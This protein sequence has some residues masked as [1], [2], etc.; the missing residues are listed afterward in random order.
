M[1]RAG[2]AL[3]WRVHQWFWREIQSAD[4]T[5]KST[6]PPTLNTKLSSID[7]SS[8]RMAK[9]WVVSSQIVKP[10]TTKP[11]NRTHYS[12]ILFD[13]NGPTLASQSSPFPCAHHTVGIPPFPGLFRHLLHCVVHETHLA[14]QYCLRSADGW[15]R[16]TSPTRPHW[17]AGKHI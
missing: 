5:D 7:R 13:P 12:L 16:E 14:Q 15:N 3:I 9:A 17:L 10:K 1:G 6:A 2:Y 8:N 11:L 4:V